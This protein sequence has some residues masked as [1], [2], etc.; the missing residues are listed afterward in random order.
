M[1]E[2]IFNN[3][4]R[5]VCPQVDSNSARLPNHYRYNPNDTEHIYNVVARPE[6]PQT[7]FERGSDANL[8]DLGSGSLKKTDKIGSPWLVDL[9][10]EIYSYL[11]SV[12]FKH[13]PTTFELDP[14]FIEME[15]L[16]DGTSL[17]DFAVAAATGLMFADQWVE[18]CKKCRSVIEEFHEL[19]MIH[20]DLHPGNIV[21][22]LDKDN[23]F[24]P[25]LIDFSYSS[26]IDKVDEK[27]ELLN[28]RN[29]Q[30]K[31]YHDYSQN[32]DWDR[33]E[34]GLTN[35][36]EDQNRDYRRGLSVLF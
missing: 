14:S 17:E 23:G 28:S 3:Q 24:I 29:V 2:Q 11:E 22:I 18:I 4:P 21:I 7:R 36:F 20:G 15:R 34:S 31:A 35:L 30:F 33:L 25:Y 9:E 1:A 8:I 19:G 27:L 10:A 6:S 5:A 12:D 16:G 32:G 13:M 26:H